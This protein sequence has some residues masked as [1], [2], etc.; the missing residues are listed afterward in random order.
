MEFIIS[1]VY[2]VII[3]LLIRSTFS[4]FV[5]AKTKKKAQQGAANANLNPEFRE[6]IQMVTDHICNL[7][8]PKT[9]AF[10][11]SKDNEKYYFCSWDCREKFIAGS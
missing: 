8:L 4:Y 1:F 9:E 7:T 2:F 10:I 5:T 6:E 11:V 3:Y